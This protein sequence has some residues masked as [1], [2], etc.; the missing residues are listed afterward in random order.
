MT[1][2]VDFLLIVCYDDIILTKEAMFGWP[3]FILATS[4][5][6]RGA[7]PSKFTNKAGMY[8]IFNRI[9]PAALASNPDSFRLSWSTEAGPG[10]YTNKA[11]MLPVI[12][13]LSS[14]ALAPSPV[15]ATWKDKDDS[16]ESEHEA[17]RSRIAAK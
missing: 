3:Q 9:S 4:S 7:G 10:K 12:N 17:D 6:P 16:E 1:I 8:F 2:F 13:Q 11:G 14:M 15:S 5:K